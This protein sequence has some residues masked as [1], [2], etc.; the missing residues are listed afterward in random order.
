MAGPCIQGWE[1]GHP[2][3]WRLG[4]YLVWLL[5][6][7]VMSGGDRARKVSPA[8]LWEKERALP[9]QS[10]ALPPSPL[11]VHNIGMATL[12]DPLGSP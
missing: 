12:A 5:L 10:P 8:P 1:C 7:G 9:Q 6:E 2:V 3:G 4:R 11:T